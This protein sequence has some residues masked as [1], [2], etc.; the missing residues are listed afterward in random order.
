MWETGPMYPPSEVIKL[1]YLM[2]RWGSPGN[3]M[4]KDRVGES[5]LE[6]CSKRVVSDMRQVFLIY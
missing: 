2:K 1:T 4:L 6:E 3:K 5:K